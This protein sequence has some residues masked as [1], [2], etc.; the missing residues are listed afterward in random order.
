[1]ELVSIFA[2]SLSVLA[3][4]LWISSVWI[5]WL[6]GP[7]HSY[8]EQPAAADQHTN[9]TPSGEADGGSTEPVNQGWHPQ[10]KEHRRHERFYWKF[11]LVVGLAGLISAIAAAVVASFAYL[12]VD[13]QLATMRDEQRPWIS[14]DRMDP[15]SSFH[16]D[17]NGLLYLRISF[18]LKNSGH[19]PARYTD[20]AGMMVV[21]SNTNAD[22]SKIKEV[23]IKERVRP[24]D[25]HAVGQPIFPGDTRSAGYG[26]E[27]LKDEEAKLEAGKTA[28]L[29]GGCVDYVYG[30][31][32][33]HHQ[34]SFVIEIDKPGPDSTFLAIDYEKDIPLAAT[35]ISFA[36]NPGLAANPD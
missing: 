22:L 14:I 24:I 23:C 2:L 26:V 29:L 7:P 11:S 21:R 36:Y 30:A 9:G 25:E 8:R 34:T 19:A 32:N 1:M 16:R 12:A 18:N 27:L 10:E 3:L 5:P 20:I 6:N 33:E 31:Q 4:L 15:I 13:G 28:I 17:Q 35:N